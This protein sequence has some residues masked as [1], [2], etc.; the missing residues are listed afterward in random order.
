MKWRCRKHLFVIERIGEWLQIYEREKGDRHLKCFPFCFVFGYS[1]VIFS[2]LI[3]LFVICIYRSHEKLNAFASAAPWRPVEIQLIFC[4]LLH[5]WWALSSGCFRCR[6]HT[7]Y[8]WC[9]SPR[10]VLIYLINWVRKSMGSG[11]WW[12]NSSPPRW[13][14]GSVPNKKKKSQTITHYLAITR[15]S[16]INKF[17][18]EEDEII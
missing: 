4:F 6:Q 7:V 13:L 11:K 16:M 5:R 1:N 18:E 10:G 12:S 17:A 3:F 9:R 2:S 8:R 15:N 14:T